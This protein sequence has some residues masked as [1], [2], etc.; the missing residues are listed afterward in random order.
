MTGEQRTADADTDEVEELPC[1]W[2]FLPLP[3]P[4]GL[5][6]HWRSEIALSPAQLVRLSGPTSGLSTSLVI[7]QLE[8]SESTVV[9][10]LADLALYAG[11][12]MGPGPEATDPP[13]PGEPP[14][15]DPPDLVA[16]ATGRTVAE[17][18]CPVHP[19]GTD[20]ELLEALDLAIEHVR[21]VQRAVAT[22]SQAPV[23]L[24]ARRTLP[25]IIPT[26]KGVIF[27][28]GG[29]GRRPEARDFVTLHIPDSASAARLSLR[30]ETFDDDTL[31]KVAWAISRV[32][33]RAPFATFTDLRREALAQWSSGSA[34]MA[35][36]A[37]A[38]A[39]EVLLDTALLLML[40][41][42]CTA[43]ADATTYFDRNTGHTRRVAK[44][45]PPRLGG[46]WDPDSRTPGGEY[47][48]T[49]VRLRHR[50]VH[51]GHEPT[52][53]ELDGAT[54]SLIGLEHYLADRLVSGHVLKRY[55]RTAVVFVGH[56][57]L[58]R[59][60][61]LTRHV[62]DL[63]HDDNEPD[64]AQTYARWSLHVDRA[65]DP[66]PAPPGA[67]ADDVDIFGHIDPDGTI[68]WIAHDPVTSHAAL[69][70]P[71]KL[72][73]AD[74]I[75]ALTAFLEGR[76]DRDL[77]D[78]RVQAAADRAVGPEAVWVPDHELFEEIWIYPGTA[79]PAP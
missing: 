11:S 61:R 26:F 43:P 12:T 32:H 36:V 19:S 28:T 63:M 25:P 8:S 34:R 9:R 78:R 46:G 6:H 65:L 79:A 67:A 49:L 10:D 2:F 37:L 15:L 22:G 38:A 44:H 13:P 69:V 75:E 20:E 40:W 16:L 50:V 45:L 17:V 66:D 41:E 30:P 59:R 39:G 52:A 18:A 35:V 3:H 33:G 77:G 55:T 4:I 53:A 14:S 72:L 54:N 51:A 73:A 23:T 56:D 48:R 7:H 76:A 29:P 68:S 62:R 58:A 47:L 64:W 5:P 1:V 24:L 27:R 21:I 31:E 60:N 57:G 42:E 71:A 74:R 70:D